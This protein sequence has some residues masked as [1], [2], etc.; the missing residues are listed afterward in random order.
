LDAPLALGFRAPELD[1]EGRLL[2]ALAVLRVDALAVFG[3]LREADALPREVDALL[4]EADPFELVVPDF[5]LLWERELA[6]AIA[7][8]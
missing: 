4:R 1:D 5:R 3:L 7:P 8:P 2:A 6:W